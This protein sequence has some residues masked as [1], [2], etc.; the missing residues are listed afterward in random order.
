MMCHMNQTNDIHTYTPTHSHV[1]SAA[2]GI[3][4]VLEKTVVDDF[5]KER[6]EEMHRMRTYCL[7]DDR[8]VLSKREN[9][10]KAR[11]SKPH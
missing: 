5:R 2:S 3:T 9:I 1:V 8:Q 10:K 6:I 11:L 7:T 4:S